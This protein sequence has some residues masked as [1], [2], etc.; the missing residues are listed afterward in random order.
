MLRG[1]C[2]APGVL[3]GA[4]HRSLGV[5]RSP[6]FASAAGWACTAC[7]RCTPPL[8]TGF[9]GS[10]APRGAAGI[11]ASPNARGWVLTVHCTGPG[12]LHRLVSRQLGAFRALHQHLA[13]ARCFLGVAAAPV[14]PVRVV[15][16]LPGSLLVATRCPGALQQLGA[17]RALHRL[18]SVSV[19]PVHC[20]GAL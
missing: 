6:C 19:F 17:S 18:C 14:H 1:F 15:P 10:R 8:C 4:E 5:A 2:I 13:A 7:R 20:T 16:V 11:A 12:A 3:H 9:W